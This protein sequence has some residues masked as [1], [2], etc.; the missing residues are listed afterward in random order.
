MNILDKILSTEKHTAGKVIT[1]PTLLSECET[2]VTIDE[3][4]RYNIEIQPGKY[5]VIKAGFT[6]G[7]PGAKFSHPNITASG[8]TIHEFKHYRRGG[9]KFWTRRA[10]VD[11]YL[12]VPRN[13]IKLIPEKGYSY[14][15]A[16]INGVKVL[17]NVSGAGGEGWTDYLT[18]FTTISVNHKL[19]DLKKI[20][21][22]A[23]RNSPFEPITPK[24]LDSNDN[25]RWNEL[26]AKA[27]PKI[28]ESI[29]KMIEE[30]KKPIVHFL[31][32]YSY[33]GETKGEAVEVQRRYKKIPVPQTPPHYFSY[34]FEPI[35]APR[36]IILATGGGKVAAKLTQIDWHQTAVANNLA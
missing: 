5:L 32:K 15:R 29:A 12:V 7:K 22:V 17:F 33:H 35:G 2:K 27:T 14:V 19:F 13:Q 18:T 23:I 11:H 9:S 30:G 20:C 4:D 1:E 28:K 36:R 6:T 8:R 34:K 3:K 31:S 26:A 10:G 25:E 24:P 16:E 21:E